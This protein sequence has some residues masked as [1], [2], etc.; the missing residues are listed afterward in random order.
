MGLDILTLY[1]VVGSSPLATRPNQETIRTTAKGHF[2]SINA[3]VANKQTN[4]Q[5]SPLPST[6]T[7]NTR[8]QEFLEELGALCQESVS[9]KDDITN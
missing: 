9:D 8:N 6:K 1:K 2:I 4:K 5:K 7:L 3:N